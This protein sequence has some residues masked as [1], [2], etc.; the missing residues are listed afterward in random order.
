MANFLRGPMVTTTHVQH[1]EVHLI[2]LDNTVVKTLWSLTSVAPAN[3]RRI[4]T[5]LGLFSGCLC[6][7]SLHW[8]SPRLS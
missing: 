6:A 7:T 8:W 4:A 1:V 2:W 3:A 5:P